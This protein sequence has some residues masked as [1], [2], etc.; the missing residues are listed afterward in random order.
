MKNYFD[1]KGQVAVITGASG[2]LGVQLANALGNQGAKLALIARNKEKLQERKDE[3][4][5][6][7]YEVYYVSAEVN[8]SVQVKNAV[9][10]I[11]DHYG[12]IDILINNAGIG[13]GDPI[14]EI[15]DE[16]WQKM[17]EVNITG[18]M[19]FSRE[20][21]KIMK[22]QGYGRV[23]NMGSIHSRVGLNQSPR[24]TPYATTKGAILMMTK[25]LATEWAGYGITVNAIGPSYFESKMT[26]KALE[27]QDFRHMVENYCPMGRIGKKGELDTTVIYLASKYSSFVT[28]QL[29]N[30]DGGW[31]AV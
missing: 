1:L 25:S 19:Y 24:M 31:T 18:A 11:M 9:Q 16:T 28:G 5:E 4:E 7:G 21:G 3:L 30:V 14:L 20:C 22:E 8:D 17:L 26:H 23:I 29:I 10:K 27:N 6:K 2:G 15:E 13:L 12:R